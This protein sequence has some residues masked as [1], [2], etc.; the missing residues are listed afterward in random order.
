MSEEERR[1]LGLVRLPETLASALQALRTDDVVTGWF[2]P[3]V[4]ESF[5]GVKETE[6]QHVADLDAASVCELYRAR[7]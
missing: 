3:D 2:A 6:L 4:I 7:Y 5:V 1:A